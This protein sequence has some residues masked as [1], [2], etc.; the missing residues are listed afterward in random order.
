VVVDHI[1]ELPGLVL[2]LVE[3]HMV[4]HMM[5]S[6]LERNAEIEKAKGIPVMRLVST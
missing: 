2:D 3:N 6:A 4:E 5:G 1:L